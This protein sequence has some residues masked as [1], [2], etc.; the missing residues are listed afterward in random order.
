MRITL[1]D[2]AGKVGLSKAA[3]SMALN[4]SPRVSQKR[5]EEVQ[6]IAVAMGYVR[7]PFLS[8]LAKYRVAKG[9]PKSQGVI[10]WIN[11]WD[12]PQQLRGY[13]EFD[14]YWRG[15]KQVAKQSGYRLDELFWPT[16]GSAKLFEQTLIKRGVLGLLI[17]P[18]PLGVNWGD[19]DWRKFSLM[20]F[21]LSVRHPD[22]NL[23]TSDH[24]RAVV[25]A[26]QKMHEYGY[27]RIGLVMSES[28][29]SS[30]G[31]NYS[32]GFAWAQKLLELRPGLPPMNKN[33]QPSAK[34][35]AEYKT[36][37]DRWMKKYKPDAILNYLAEV[38]AYLRELGYRIP[39][40]VAIA[41]TSVCDIPVDTGIDQHSRAIGQIAAE[42]LIKQISLNERGEPPAPCRILV[43]SR[44]QDGK[45]LPRLR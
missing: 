8:G 29:D 44:W 16:D 23:V 20:R 45:T 2:I 42:M 26:I 6:R 41:G 3:V 40:D 18:H 32:G 38:P 21:G 1:K 30:W 14:L 33:P 10:A 25:M 31:G 7:D 37:L 12:K 9:V 13:R 35:I 34:G 36:A 5:R 4:N 22:S 27:Q 15:A 24:Q 11:H 17:P 39:Q 19:F 43:E 28:S